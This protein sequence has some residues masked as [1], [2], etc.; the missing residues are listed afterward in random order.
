MTLYDFLSTLKTNAKVMVK[1]EEETFTIFA[2]SI[3][4]LDESVQE[5]EIEKWEIAGG[6]TINVTL[7]TIISA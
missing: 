2:D 1:N 7:E 4:A 3:K 6:Q 5:K